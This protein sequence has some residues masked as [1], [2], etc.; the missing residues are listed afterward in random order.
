MLVAGVTCSPNGP[1][2]QGMVNDGRAAPKVASPEFGDRKPRDKTASEQ[3]QSPDRDSG[4]ANPIPTATPGALPQSLSP[5]LDLREAIEKG[6]VEVS[7]TGD[8]LDSVTVQL[9][10]KTETGI[11]C[12]RWYGVSAQRLPSTEYDGSPRSRG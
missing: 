3:P 12:F 7:A 2:E 9:R 8:D 4:N 10:A 11:T 6:L 5:R 1:R